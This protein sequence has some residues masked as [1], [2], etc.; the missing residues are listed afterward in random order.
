LQEEIYHSLLS[1]LSFINRFTDDLEIQKLPTAPKQ[2]GT[3]AAPRWIAPPADVSKI[4]FNDA[5]SK[6]ARLATM[7]AIAMDETGA[8]LG[9]LTIVVRGADDPEILEV[10]ACREGMALASDLCHTRVKCGQQ[11]QWMIHSCPLRPANPRNDGNQ[12]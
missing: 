9:A 2:G 8:F 3:V 5:L 6:N 10:V 12:G 11:N 4:N 1:T 7:A